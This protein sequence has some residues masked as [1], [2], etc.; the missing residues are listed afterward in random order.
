MKEQSNVVQ[1]GLAKR[2]DVISSM[3]NTIQFELDGLFAECLPKYRREEEDEKK[4]A[5]KRYDWVCHTHN[6][7]LRGI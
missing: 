3:R 6:K 1:A 4:K 7:N 5:R 2:H